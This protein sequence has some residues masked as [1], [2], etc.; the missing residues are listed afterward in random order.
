MVEDAVLNADAAAN[1]PR[2]AGID[3]NVMDSGEGRREPMLLL[4]E[5]SPCCREKQGLLRG[6][7]PDTQ[8]QTWNPRSES[9]MLYCSRCRHEYVVPPKE[10]L[11]CDAA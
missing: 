6:R 1:E 5:P 11:T 4:N 2:D 3:V 8:A 10:A 9:G 7:H